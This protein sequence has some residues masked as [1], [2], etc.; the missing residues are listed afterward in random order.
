[1]HRGFVIL[2]LYC[3]LVL[4][5]VTHHLRCFY[6]VLSINLFLTNKI[7]IWTDTFSSFTAQNTE[8]TKLIISQNLQSN[9]VI[10]YMCLRKKLLPLSGFD[11]GAASLPTFLW[12]QAISADYFKQVVSCS[13]RFTLVC[14]LWFQFKNK[15]KIF[16]SLISDIWNSSMQCKT[17]TSREVSQTSSC[18]DLRNALISIRRI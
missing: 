16:V 11:E 8:L 4:A 3:E 18:E 2:G 9:S 17:E 5:R 14:V 12:Q 13:L 1:M 7:V 15:I 10:E 6:F